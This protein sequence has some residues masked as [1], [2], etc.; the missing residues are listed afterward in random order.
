MSCLTLKELRKAFEYK[1]FSPI[2]I[3]L[4]WW[5]IG[6]LVGEM[7]DNPKLRKLLEWFYLK[8]MLIQK[9]GLEIGSSI[10]EMR[11]CLVQFYIS[12]IW[13]MTR[14]HHFFSILSC[15][16]YLQVVHDILLLKAPYT[17][18]LCSVVLSQK[19]LPMTSCW[20]QQWRYSSF[21]REIFCCM[22]LGVG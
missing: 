12:E 10:I 18:L 13:I 1:K 7:C 9:C 3:L 20:R 8:N 16:F 2:S 21:D 22:A 15:N 4:M 11:H 6:H 19:L 17:I 14:S 5:L